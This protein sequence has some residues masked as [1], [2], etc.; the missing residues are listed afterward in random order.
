MTMQVTQA[1]DRTVRPTAALAEFVTDLRLEAIPVE[2]RRAVLNALLDTIG[3]GLFGADF[4]W[5][6]IV[7]DWIR[8]QEGRPEATLWRGGGYRAPAANIALGLGTMIHSF[9]FDDY[10]N[11]KI[12][13]GAAVVP[14]AITLAEARGASGRDLLTAL[15]A[16]YEVMTRVSLG[17]GPGPSRMQG[18]HLTGTTGTFGAAAAA[19]SLLGLDADRTASALGLAGTQSAGLWA[20]TA[21]GSQ[22]KRFHP[23]R[24]AQSGLI[25]AALAQRGYAGP[26]RILEAEDGGFCRATSDGFDFG[27]LV[28]G[29]G[30][31][32]VAGDVTI[33]PYACCGSLHSSIDAVREITARRPIDPDAIDRIVCHHSRIV[34]QQCGFAYEPLS[35]LQA[36]MSAQYALAVAVL[37]GQALV[38]QFSADRIGQ[39]DVVA[40]AKRVEFAV[41]PEIDRIYPEVFAG[42]VEIVLRDGTRLDRRVDYP[43]GSV[44]NP[45][46]EADLLAKFHALAGRAIGRDR[47]D[48]VVQMV[49][50]IEGLPDVRALTT[51]LA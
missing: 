10:H 45:L 4:E 25:A 19:A 39:P 8:D 22:S 27:R 11:A 32:F 18:W 41:D 35:V 28:D 24:S 15:V 23:G 50:E 47:A 29:L 33:K 21:D 34:L 5:S 30:E 7:A 37:D 31:R 1:T 12:H 43:R 26:T 46:P 3:C 44:E 49:Q 40:L 14:A 2:T 6:R 20:F 51:E 38:D 48:R 17:T 36:Q 13:P 16:G 9:D 42:R